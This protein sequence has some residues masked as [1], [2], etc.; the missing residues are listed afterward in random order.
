[1]NEILLTNLRIR[2][3]GEARLAQLIIELH[4]NGRQDD[5]FYAACNP[6]YRHTLYKEFG[7]GIFYDNTSQGKGY[8]D[9]PTEQL[10]SL[11]KAE[12]DYDIKREEQLLRNCMYRDDE[13]KIWL[14]CILDPEQKQ[15]IK[16]EYEV[17]MNMEIYHDIAQQAG[18]Y[19]ENEWETDSE[20][21]QDWTAK[22]AYFTRD[23]ESLPEP[24]ETYYQSDM[25][26]TF[27]HVYIDG[28]E[29]LG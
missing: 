10:Y 12:I 15:E 26:E 27:A 6:M 21:E 22:E 5:V 19:E 24:E 7:I 18:F 4:K 1:M 20:T 17:R 25:T 3:R 13:H 23:L 14:D 16:K 8:D 2:K 29:Y 11:S 28:E 9:D